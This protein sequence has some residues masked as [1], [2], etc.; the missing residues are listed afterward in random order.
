RYGTDAEL[1]TATKETVHTLNL[2]YDD[3]GNFPDRFNPF[4]LGPHLL[5]HEVA[6]VLHV[7]TVFVQ[8]S[9]QPEKVFDLNVLKALIEPWANSEHPAA[10]Q[11]YFHQQE[12]ALNTL[13][14]E[15]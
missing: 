7:L 5:D 12:H 9:L 10:E 1:L 11:I 8:H 2:Y 15:M 6:A 3:P 13:G 14:V 4:L